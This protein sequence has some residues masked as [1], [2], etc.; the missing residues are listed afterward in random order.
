LLPQADSV[1][2]RIKD[3]A[4]NNLRVSSQA[5]DKRWGVHIHPN[6]LS[7][8]RER[9]DSEKTLARK[10]FHHPLCGRDKPRHTQ[11][12]GDERPERKVPQIR[13][14]RE[15]AQYGNERPE[16]LENC[17][18]RSAVILYRRTLTT[19]AFIIFQVRGMEHATGPAGLPAVT[20]LLK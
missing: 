7:L 17:R 12:I 20:V 13:Q 16:L 18:A 14:G 19:A 15:R 6:T 5:I 2:C 10:E 3:A 8:Y 4:S 1:S 11:S 9:I